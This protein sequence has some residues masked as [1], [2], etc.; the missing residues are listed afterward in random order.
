M[1]RGRKPVE[2]SGILDAACRV[3]SKKGYFQATVDDVMAAAGV[4]KGTVYRHFNDKEGLLVALLCRMAEELSGRVSKAV[5]PGRPL[6]ENL[7]FIAREILEFFSGRPDLLR[8]YVR[9]GTLSIPVVRKTMGGIIRQFNNRTAVLL[10]GRAMFR[11]ASV[12]NGMVFGLLRQKFGITDEP[13][14]PE[15]DASYLVSMFL[16]GLR[17]KKS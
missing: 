2:P 9:E 7:R 1:K 16:Y 15:K 3:F 13:V 12:F 14:Y 5:R 4:G 17:G 11:A 8:I 10:G 6:D